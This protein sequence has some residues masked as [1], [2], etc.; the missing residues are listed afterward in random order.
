MM[1]TFQRDEFQPTA[2]LGDSRYGTPTPRLWLTARPGTSHRRLSAALHAAAMLAELETP[3]TERWV[4][5]VEVAGDLRGHVY[6]ETLTGSA[7]E[8]ERAMKLLGVVLQA[9]FTNGA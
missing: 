1:P 7:A 9:M 8:A 4:I 2:T 6:V 3:A 5:G